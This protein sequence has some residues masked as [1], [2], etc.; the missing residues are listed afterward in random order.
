M[1]DSLSSGLRML[2]LALNVKSRT[3]D[4][5]DTV[6]EGNLSMWYHGEDDSSFPSSLGT[7]NLQ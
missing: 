6:Q 4:T 2:P 1:T 7:M 5:S 3:L